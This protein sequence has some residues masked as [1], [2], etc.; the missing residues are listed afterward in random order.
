MSMREEFVRSYV[1]QQLAKAVSAGIMRGTTESADGHKHSFAVMFNEIEKMFIGSTSYDG[2]GPHLHHIMASIRDV[3]ESHLKNPPQP[4]TEEDIVV[5]VNEANSPANLRK[6][7]DFYNLKEIR[8]ETSA[9]GMDGH[10]HNVVLRYAG[11]NDEALNVPVAPKASAHIL[12]AMANV[13]QLDADIASAK[14]RSDEAMK[15]LEE[16]LTKAIRPDVVEQEGAKKP[17]GKDTAQMPAEN[18]AKP[19]DTATM[20][21]DK[22][23]VGIEAETEFKDEAGDVSSPQSGRDVADAVDGTPKTAAER[24][25]AEIHAKHDAAEAELM[26]RIKHSM[27]ARK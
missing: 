17:T 3:T 9:G 1:E 19:A 27:E 23:D 6:I 18:V 12:N 2:G 13:E 14:L 24:M 10:S 5:E 7:L 21:T 26:E 22:M 25:I 16:I 8:L 11:H 20:P 15:K 4:R